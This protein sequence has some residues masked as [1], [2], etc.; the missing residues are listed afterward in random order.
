MH[1]VAVLLIVLFVGVQSPATP[2][3]HQDRK[4]RIEGVVRRIGTGEAL[5]KAF[6]QMIRS[7]TGSLS[8]PR[9][10]TATTDSGGRFTL[11]DIEPGS[12][13]VIVYR[14][15]YVRQEYGGQEAGRT[16]I[17]LEVVAGQQ[18]ELAFDMVP[19]ATISG[20]VYDHEGEPMANVTVQALQFRFGS[21]GERRLTPFQGVSTNDLGE[22]RLYWLDPGEYFVSAAYSGSAMFSPFARPS[23]N[24][25]PSTEGQ[26]TVFYPGVLDQTLASTIE[27]AAGDD[28]AGIDLT[29]IRA[30]TATVKGRVISTVPGLPATGSSVTVLPRTPVNRGPF[31]SAPVDAQGNFEIRGVAPGSYRVTA[32]L[33]SGTNRYVARVPIEVV[34]QD[35]ENIV[36]AIGPGF[37]LP[38]RVYVEGPVDPA[39]A[40]D[41]QGV[42]WG[43]LRVFVLGEEDR[44]LGAN[45][46]LELDGNFVLE[47]VPAGRFQVVVSGR[48]PD[49]YLKRILFGGEEIRDGTIEVVGPPEGTIDLLWSANSGR[50]EGVANDRD[51]NVLA[52]TRIVLIPDAPLRDRTRLYKTANLDQYGKF[53]LRGITPGDYTIFAWENVDQ[54]QYY[55]ADFMR[56]FESRGERVS[57]DEGSRL[58][59][60]VQIIPAGETP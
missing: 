50:V 52:G 37:D 56:R 51:G 28:L 36:L 40:D 31:A 54:F 35:I 21:D 9:P 26:V 43:R 59:V 48:S 18:L 57:V 5:P 41:I 22:Y 11:D 42:D 1:P 24:L 10:L 29:L 14:N 12:Y 16:G 32:S 27:V 4:A 55:N 33:R 60:N 44:S 45:A 58:Q 47:N 2:E 20:R 46:V 30:T 39:S 8:R 38:G 23:R 49:Y 25:I 19:A 53:T 13:R 17:L 34:G 15:G 3:T 7:N 6:V